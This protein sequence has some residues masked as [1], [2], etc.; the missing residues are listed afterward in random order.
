[1]NDLDNANKN[2]N[3]LVSFSGGK[4]SC[5]ALYRAQQRGMLIKLL[6]TAM[7]ETGSRA[8]SHG[9]PPS[10]LKAQALSLNIE[11]LFYHTTWETY[12]EFFI[13]TLKKARVEKNIRYGVFGDI[14]I[15][16]HK[17]WEDKV[18]NAAGI[19]AYL[20]LW[21]QSRRDMVFEFLSLGFKAIVVCVNGSYLSETFC[22]RLF[23]HSFIEDLPSDIDICGKDYVYL[24]IYSDLYSCVYTQL[25]VYIYDYVFT[26][27]HNHVY[28]YVYILYV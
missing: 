26:Y 12:E 24:F 22:G 20:P 17:E 9:V 21:L 10:L 5:L 15:E 11:I 16:T 14:D 2:D 4:D 18:C 3:A 7:D 27:S 6:I 25:D 1:M 19:E 28:I 8:R 23:D 13:E